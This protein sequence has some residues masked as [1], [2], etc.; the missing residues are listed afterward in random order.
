[1]LDSNSH[2]T[3]GWGLFII[4]LWGCAKQEVPPP[5]EVATIARELTVIEGP[6]DVA[7]TGVWKSPKLCRVPMESRITKA[8]ENTMI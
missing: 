6:A 7:L 2:L 3:A 1:M 5:P 4:L 8:A